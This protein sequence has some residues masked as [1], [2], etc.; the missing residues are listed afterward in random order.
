MCNPMIL[1]AASTAVTVGGQLA[2]GRAAKQAGD[3]QAKQLEYQAAVD[4]DIAL[5]QAEQIRRQG[6]RDRSSSVAA[7]A[8]SGV[9]IGEGSALDAERQVLED[10]EV[11]AAMAILSG[12]RSAMGTRY[13]AASARAAGRQARNASYIQAAGTLLNAGAQGMRASGGGSL[14]GWDAKGFNGTN[15]RSA[16]SVGNNMDW[17]MRNGRSG[18]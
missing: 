17:F 6:Q 3:E 1:L 12:K 14:S 9:R 4:E 15:D 16:V 10:S 5:S 7:A 8:A 13:Q 11:D 2:Q 18:D